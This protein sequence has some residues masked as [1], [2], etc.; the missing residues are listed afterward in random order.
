[1]IMNESEEPKIDFK[2]L[3]KAVKKVLAFKPKKNTPG[4]RA[5]RDSNLRTGVSPPA[6]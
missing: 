1:M 3:D 5:V 4:W 6:T 2:V